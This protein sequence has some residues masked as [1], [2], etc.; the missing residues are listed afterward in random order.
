[1]PGKRAEVLSWRQVFKRILD[2]GA[3]W[4]S[5]ARFEGSPVVRVCVTNGRT[6]RMRLDGLADAL[7]DEG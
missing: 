1:M 5:E 4:I 7:G 6:T 2:G 3:Y